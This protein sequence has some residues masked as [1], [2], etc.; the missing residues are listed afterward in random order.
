MPSPPVPVSAVTDAG[1]NTLLVTF[2]K[3]V[4]VSD[5]SAVLWSVRIDDDERIPTNLRQSGPN[6]VLMDLFQAGSDIG[7]D[8][9]TYVGGALILTDS[10][11]NAVLGFVDF[12]ITQDV[13]VENATFSTG[14]GDTVIVFTDNIVLV[15]DDKKPWGVRAGSV[16]Q[17]VQ[18]VSQTG[19]NEITLS[20]NS[21]GPAAPGDFVSYDSSGGCVETELGARV[22]SVTEFP[23]TIIA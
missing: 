4:F 14:T 19:V 13:E 12:P 22:G 3:P 16:K 1:F 18:T 11:G 5:S 2:S 7:I 20:T 23:L 9:V 17:T 15:D 10:N 8:Q 21:D 6:G